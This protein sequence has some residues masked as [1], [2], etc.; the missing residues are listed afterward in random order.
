MNRA[1]RTAVAVLAIVFAIGGMSHG[2]FEVLQGNAPTNGVIIEAIS[3]SRQ[4][5][6]YG[7]ETAFT[8]IPNFLLTGI[9]AITVGLAIIVWSVGYLPTR[10]G[11]T[12]LLLLYVLLFLVGGGIGQLPF[13]LTAW[14][15]ATRINQPLTWWR[16]VLPQGLRGGLARLWRWTMI[17]GAAGVL[18]ALEIAIFGYFPGVTDADQLLS[19]V[20]AALGSAWLLFLLTFV[21]AFAYDIEHPAGLRASLHPARLAPSP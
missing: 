2:F 10:H 11:A 20:F 14:V 9:A 12:V 16:K 15:F 13:F 6:A 8:L 7:G 21:S 3:E 19:I 5:W 18:L 1:T 4:T 17:A